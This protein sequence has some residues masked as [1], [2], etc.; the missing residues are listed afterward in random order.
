M[1]QMKNSRSKKPFPIVP[2]L[3]LALAA[4]VLLTAGGFGFA[5]SQETHDSFCVSCHSQP[6]TTFF[7]RSSADQPVDMAS[8]H[9][10]RKPGALTVTQGKGPPGAC[11]PNCS[12]LAIR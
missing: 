10:P 3:I 9:T 2:A 8:F 5:A 6:E 12:G 11:R 4:A 1:A 7:Q